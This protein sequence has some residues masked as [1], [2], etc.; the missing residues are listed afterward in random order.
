MSNE[1]KKILVVDDSPTIISLVS[2]RLE[3]GGY[4]VISAGDG[5]SGLDKMKESM[6]D[7]VIFDIQMPG[8]DGFQAC[9]AAKSDPLLKNIPIIFLTSTDEDINEEKYRSAGAD[10]YITKPYEGSG[11]LEKVNS[12]LKDKH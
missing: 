8:I 6:P 10:G 12:F 1:K 11:I 7:L 3:F 4:E 9:R 2:K 5:R